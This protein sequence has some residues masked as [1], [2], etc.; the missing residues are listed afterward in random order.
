MA[1]STAVRGNGGLVVELTRPALK[2][3]QAEARL[4]LESAIGDLGA[5]RE[6]RE[7]SRM[8]ACADVLYAVGRAE[9]AWGLEDPREEALLKAIRFSAEAVGLLRQQRDAVVAYIA[10]QDTTGEADPEH[11]GRECFL[12]HVLDR[13]LGEGV[14]D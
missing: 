9:S 7:R 3:L 5:D 1:S 4:S 11:M 2:A 13:V 10:E 6:G 12:A 14:A 8:N